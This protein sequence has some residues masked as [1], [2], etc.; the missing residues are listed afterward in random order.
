MVAHG[1]A[2]AVAFSVRS[3]AKE[4]A[5]AHFQ[6]WPP[7][8]AETPGHGAWA[9]MSDHLC[10]KTSW[11]NFVLSPSGDYQHCFVGLLQSCS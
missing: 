5:V 9:L 1:N 7:G 2:I 3:R 8:V 6:H 11:H 10:F 4:R